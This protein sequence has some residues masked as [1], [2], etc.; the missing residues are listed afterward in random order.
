MG[1]HSAK[2]NI[3]ATKIR[4]YGADDV[5]ILKSV[6]NVVGVAGMCADGL[7]NAGALQAI[8]NR[9]M[10]RIS[11]SSRQV[12]KRGHYGD[13]E[14]EENTNALRKMHTDGSGEP[15]WYSLVRTMMRKGYLPEEIAKLLKVS[16]AELSKALVPGGV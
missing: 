6:M 2:H 14:E 7:L 9:G 4:S 11:E 16:R 3:P 5:R 13:F 1:I 10:H 15:G 8:L 12:N